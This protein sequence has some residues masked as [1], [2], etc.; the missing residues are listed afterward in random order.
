M[1]DWILENWTTIFTVIGL[2]GTVC[3][4]VVGL[5]GNCKWLGF[6]VKICDYMSVFNTQKTKPKLKKPVLKLKKRKAKNN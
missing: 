6:F 3:S 4:T 1:L 5:L 2:V